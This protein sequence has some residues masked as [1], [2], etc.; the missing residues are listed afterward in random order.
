VKAVVCA[1]KTD[2]SPRAVAGDEARAWA[3]ARGMSYVE[4]SSS[5][6]IGHEEA[7]QLLAEVSS[8]H[9]TRIVISLFTRI[10]N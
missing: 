4:A 7:F 8:S 2:V 6:G 5:L 3:E 9:L 10:D 1:C